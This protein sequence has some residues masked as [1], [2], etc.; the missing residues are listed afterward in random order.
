[1]KIG[2]I[3]CCLSFL[4]KFLYGQN[5]IIPKGEYMDTTLNVSSKCSPPYNIFY[6]QLKAKYPV[7]SATL[8]S[9]SRAFMKQKGQIYSGNGYVTFKFF[10][11]CE[12]TMSSV[13]VMQTDD[14][15]KAIHFEKS[16]VNDLY[17]YLKTMN[18]WKTNL[19]VEDLKNINYIAFIS[20]K[21]KNGEVINIIP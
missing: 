19:K 10:I 20:F 2:F 16:F 4:P 6:Y 18:K 11:D 12:G 1:M 21:I 14:N 8:L 15:Y 7:A 9:E 5:Y 17:N 3:I 13:K